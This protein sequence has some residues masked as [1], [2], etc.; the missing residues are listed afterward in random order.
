[1]MYWMLRASGKA[2][3]VGFIGILVFVFTFVALMLAF[4]QEAIPKL[5]EVAQL[6]AE[7][8]E[9]RVRLAQ[10][11]ATVADR[12]ARLASFELMA[13]RTALEKEFRELLKP[14]DGATFDWKTKVFESKEPLP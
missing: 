13:E 1:M 3:T 10:C 14:A 6:K 12:E 7:L 2:I 8:H 9:M 4:G 11:S 5:T